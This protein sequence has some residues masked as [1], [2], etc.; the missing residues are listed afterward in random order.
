[1]TPDQS[2]DPIPTKLHPGGSYRYTAKGRILGGIG[3]GQGREGTGRAD[4]VTGLEAAFDPQPGP[5]VSGAA[6]PT[7]ITA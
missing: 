6:R 7:A 5:N 1:M 4:F 2:H 3:R